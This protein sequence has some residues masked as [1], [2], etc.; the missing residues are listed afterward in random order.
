MQKL[1]IPCVPVYLPESPEAWDKQIT[2]AFLNAEHLLEPGT[3]IYICNPLKVY[4][5]FIPAMNKAFV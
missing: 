2:P 3:A 1:F 5:L 4:P